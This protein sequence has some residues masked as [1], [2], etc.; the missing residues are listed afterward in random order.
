M[1][2]LLV[3]V[4]SAYPQ[5]KEAVFRNPTWVKVLYSHGFVPGFVRNLFF[6]STAGMIK[7]TREIRIQKARKGR[8]PPLKNLATH[9]ALGLAGLIPLYL[10]RGEL[11][12]PLLN[13]IGFVRVTLL[14]ARVQF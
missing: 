7:R 1:W 8:R 9:P 2:N 3:Y 12:Y 13:D 11:S 5:Q 10:A 14:H 4:T 6:K